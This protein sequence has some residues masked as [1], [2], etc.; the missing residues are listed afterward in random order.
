MN[1]QIIIYHLND[2]HARISTHDENEKSIG[3]DQIS[4]VINLSRLKNKNTFLFHAGDLL[5]G[6][7]R[8]NI[9]QGNNMIPLLNSIHLNALC[10]GNHEFNFSLEQLLTIAKHLH[11]YV[12]CSN[13]IYKDTKQYTFLPY[14]IYEVDINQ[15]DYI[16]ENSNNSYKDNLKIGIFGLATP[17]TA[18]KANPQYVANLEFLNP[19]STAQNMVNLLK[20]NCDI[21]IAL[22]HLGIDAS[23][24]FTSKKIAEQVNGIDVIIDGHS[25]HTLEQGLKINNTLIVQAGSHNQYLGKIIINIKD[26][27][28]NNISAELLNENQVNKIINNKVD[29]YIERELNK[30]EN[31]TDKQ[32]NKIITYS[33]WNLSGNRLIVRQQECE[34]GNL[35]ADSIQWISNTDFAVI[36]GGNIRT[37]LKKGPITYKDILAILPFNSIMNIIKIPGKVIKEMLEHSIEYVPASFG[38]F[39]HISSNLKFIYDPSMNKNNRIKEIYINNQLIDMNKIYTITITDFMY[40]G[41][42]A[43]Y[44]L[45]D[46]EKIGECGF[47]NEIFIK[48]LNDIDVKE[49]SFKLGRIIKKD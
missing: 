21:I 1:K 9:S 35:I 42:D 10:P 4:K 24:E 16:S 23:S 26:K 17:E 18:Y 37:D 31:E 41:G 13:I 36:N 28:I 29:N 22:T 3:L 34:L 14:I 30:I 2:T 47:S 11:A 5:H 45:I 40:I 15:N 20:N 46:L 19:I 6:T 39:L 7:P 8:I 33:N 43:Y 25:H 38:G 44:M 32:L 27:K 48:Y 49:Q 12:L